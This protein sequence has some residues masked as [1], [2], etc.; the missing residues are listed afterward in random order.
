MINNLK[1]YLQDVGIDPKYFSFYEVFVLLSIFLIPVFYTM[2]GI[3]TLVFVDIATARM[4]CKKDEWVSA[5]LFHSVLKM[6]V[7][8]MLC[9][10]ALV[11]DA[12]LNTPG[13]FGENLILKVS[14]YFIAYVELK[15]IGENVSKKLGIDWF[16]FIKGYL[17]KK[18]K[19]EK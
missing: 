4:A 6:V 5:K 10:A 17:N 11:T 14:T 13:V 7:Y 15:S 9:I 19:P 1:Q 8:L 16:T 18:L 12:M 2:V 3:G